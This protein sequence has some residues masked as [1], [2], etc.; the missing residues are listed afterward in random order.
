MVKFG[1][2]D[3][4][5]IDVTIQNN[6]NFFINPNILCYKYCLYRINKKKIIPI[7]LNKSQLKNKTFNHNKSDTCAICKNNGEDLLSIG[8]TSLKN[9]KQCQKF[10]DWSIHMQNYSNYECVGVNKFKCIINEN[11]KTG[12][13]CKKCRYDK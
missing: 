2:K 6:I 9:C 5:N 1:D 11:V 13:Y 4:K 12:N 7:F 8:D 3:Y 10:F